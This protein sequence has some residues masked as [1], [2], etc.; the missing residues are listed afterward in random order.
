M[1]SLPT[2]PAEIVVFLAC[3]SFLVFL[4]NQCAAL[5]YKLRGK[6]TPGEMQAAADALSER[7]AKLETRIDDHGERINKLEGDVRDI[8]TKEVS[9]IYNRVNAVAD[10]TAKLT[11][12][13]DTVI[14]LLQKGS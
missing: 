14:T 10:E 7:L 9:K 4:V 2:V 11:G 13:V 6:P 5:V 8:I 1:E 12:K 3:L